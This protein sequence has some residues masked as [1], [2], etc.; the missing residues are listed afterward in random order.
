M[1]KNNKQV[2]LVSKNLVHLSRIDVIDKLVEDFYF[3]LSGL[4]PKKI[5]KKAAIH[6][7]SIFKYYLT[8]KTLQ[9]TVLIVTKRKDDWQLVFK[10]CPSYIDH[11]ESFLKLEKYIKKD[12]LILSIGDFYKGKIVKYIN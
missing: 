3:F 7:K 9:E 5:A 6:S 1:D 10:V 2:S 4:T 8:N 11:D 12:T